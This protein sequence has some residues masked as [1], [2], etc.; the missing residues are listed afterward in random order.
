M[1]I[2]DTTPDNGAEGIALEQV[3]SV[4]FDQE[5]DLDSATA[6]NIVLASSASKVTSRGPGFEDF[7]PLEGDLLDSYTFTGVVAS[8]IATDDNLT[9]TLTPDSPLEADKL[10]RLIVSTDLLTRTISEVVADGGNTSTGSFE[11]SGPYTG[12]AAD[13]F[14]IEIA[15]TGVLG[16]GTFTYTRASDG[17]VSDAIIT[18]RR[19]E[20]E[21]GVFIEFKAGSFVE[22]DSWT[23]TTTP[24]ESLDS[25]YEFSFTTGGSTHVQVSED[26]PSIRIERREVE[27]INRIDGAPAVDSGSLALVS[28]LPQNQSTNIPLSNRTIVLEFSKEIDPASLDAVTID[29]IMENLP[30]DEQEQYSTKLRVN[31]E[32][33]GKKLILTFNG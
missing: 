9:F 13:T 17:L 33:S 22:A 8:T 3:V 28:I 25:I 4:V 6:G 29:V 26:T 15:T 24:G 5:V 16:V 27:G 18:D 30:L 20:L 2:L 21:D 12:P 32:V 1:V 31:A 19:V 11:L 7:I 10:Y 23:F 14:T